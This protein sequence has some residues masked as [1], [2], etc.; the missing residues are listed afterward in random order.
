MTVPTYCGSVIETE[1]LEKL[2]SVE[3]APVVGST[4]CTRRLNRL[5][6]FGLGTVT[7]TRRLFPQT[8]GLLAKSVSDPP[9]PTAEANPA[10]LIMATD[11]FDD[12]QVAPARGL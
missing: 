4:S 12:A 7:V 2:S 1:R 9:E 3:I 8:P 6:G 10:E 5:F 11:W